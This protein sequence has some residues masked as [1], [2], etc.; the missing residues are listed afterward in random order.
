MKA[1]VYTQNGKKTEDSIVLAD[2]VFKAEIKEDLMAQAVYTYQTNQRQGTVRTKSRAE[3][4][5]G[6]RKPWRQK[7]PDKARHGSTREPQWVGGGHAHAIRPK[8]WKLRMPLRMKRLALFSA[9]SEKVAE[10]SLKVLNKIELKDTQLTKQ[11]ADV[12]AKFAKDEKVL[13]VLT[14]DDSVAVLGAKK[15]DKLNT[16]Y[17]GE[18]NIIDVLNNDMVLVTSAVAD[19]MNE[20]WGEKKS[21]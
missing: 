6:G 7:T 14:Q 18:L 4:S 11:L 5:G 3:V 2:N 16:V 13:L 12:Y 19:K 17:V 15:L 1:A 9:L 21:K 8:S 20:V 10:E